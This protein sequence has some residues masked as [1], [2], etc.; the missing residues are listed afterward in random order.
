MWNPVVHQGLPERRSRYFFG[1]ISLR[2]PRSSCPCYKTS[3][4]ATRSAPTPAISSVEPA[5][6]AKSTVACLRSRTGS[7]SNPVT[8]LSDAPH[9]VQKRAVATQPRPQAGHAAARGTPAGLAKTAAG[10]AVASTLR[11]LPC[12]SARFAAR[13]RRPVLWADRTNAAPAPLQAECDRP[14]QLLTV[15]NAIWPPACRAGRAAPGN[16]PRCQNR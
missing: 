2:L 15:P 7:M 5:M 8:P 3:R 14:R 11:A 12:T 4:F 9:Q 16:S 6:S 13:M 1:R 10:R